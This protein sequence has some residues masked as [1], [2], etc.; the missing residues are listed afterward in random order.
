MPRNNQDTF[1]GEE[2]GGI[3]GLDRWNEFIYSSTSISTPTLY[4]TGVGNN[5]NITIVTSNKYTQP[6]TIQSAVV[7]YSTLE[8][9]A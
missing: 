8:R 4:T 3:W 1:D 9:M 7:D 6:H 5:M 2:V